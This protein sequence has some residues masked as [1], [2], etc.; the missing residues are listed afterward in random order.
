MTWGF[1]SFWLLFFLFF[2]FLIMLIIFLPTHRR[3]RRGYVCDEPL[4]VKRLK[5]RPTDLLNEVDI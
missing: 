3:Y 1:D 4:S 2:L 5:H